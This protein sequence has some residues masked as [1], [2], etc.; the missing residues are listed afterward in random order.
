[1]IAAA[2]R[3][4]SF[5]G[6]DGFGLAIQAYQKRARSRD[7]LQRRAGARAEPADD[8]AAG[9]GRLLG[10]RDQARAGARPRRLSGVHPQGDDRP[11]LRRLRAATAGAAAAHLPAIRHPQRADGGDRAR[12]CGRDTRIR[13]S[14]PA[15]HGRGAVCAIERG[16]SRASAAAPMRRSAA[17]AICWPIWCGA[18]WRTAPIRRSWRSPPTTPCRS[19]R[20]C[21]ARPTSSALPPTRGIRISACRAI[22]ISRN[23]QNSRGIEFGDRAALNELVSAIAAE[24]TPAAGSI[25]DATPADAN[26]AIA[27]GARGIQRLEPDAGTA[28]RGHPRTRRRPA[29]A[30][31]G[32]F[33][34]AAATRGRQDP[35]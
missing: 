1:M 11:E 28:A 12:A 8:A 19:R 3:D 17:T 2:F 10:H 30:A 33:H 9:E 6:W 21:G 26:A 22:S 4:A 29:G 18:C 15:R 35:R 16:S 20:C 14:A 32:A 23:V 24:T 31:A 34:R 5:K 13:V 7:R 27:S 25:A